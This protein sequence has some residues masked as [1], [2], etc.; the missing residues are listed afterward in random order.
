MKK[1]DLV[2]WARHGERTLGPV[3]H[4]IN[5]VIPGDVVNN[6]FVVNDHSEDG[7]PCIIQQHGWIQILNNGHGISDA[8]NTALKNVETDYFCSFEQ[9]VLLSPYWWNR[10]SRLILNKPGVAAASGLRFLPQNNF[11]FNI[12]SYTLARRGKEDIS[13]YGKTLDNTIWN[14]NIL[15][16]CGGFPKLKYAGIDT[17]LHHLFD[18]KGY[19][20]MVDYDV[21]SLHLHSDGLLNELQHYYFYGLS[22]PELYRQLGKFCGDYQGENWLCYLAKF[23]KSPVSSLKMALKMRDVRLLVAYPSVRFCWLMGYLKGLEAA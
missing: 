6:K 2:M 8:A 11:C 5:Q 1:Y 12:D 15:R 14:T 20:W 16:E 9:D 21:Q 4:R 22:L 23:V 10:V 17:Y 13:N 19:K 3:L 7:I 18:S